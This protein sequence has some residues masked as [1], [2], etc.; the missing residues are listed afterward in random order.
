MPV[1]PGDNRI[2]FPTLE[3]A[4]GEGLVLRQVVMGDS[5]TGKN[6]S[7]GFA[8]RDSS[9]N[10]IL[11]QLTAAGRLPVDTEGNNG[12][13]SEQ[14][15]EDADGSVS[16]TFSTIASITLA[17]SDTIDKIDYTVSG[18]KGG[19]FQLVKSDNGVE[20]VLEDVILESGQYTFA[21][22]FDT[23]E[24]MGATGAQLLFIRAFNWES[25]V[26]NT[27]ALRSSLRALIRSV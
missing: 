16:G 14:R 27:S 5:P 4:S 26:N 20:E 1:L 6:G 25:N 11:P 21:N 22:N 10:V 18:R 8:F 15:G 19:Y 24:V 12:T 17:A 9:G 13:W 7:I 23:L 2:T 3:G